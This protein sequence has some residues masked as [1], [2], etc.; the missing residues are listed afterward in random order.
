[1]ST[2]RRS[3]ITLHSIR[4]NQKLA[5][6]SRPIRESQL[7][8]ASLQLQINIRNKLLPSKRSTPFAAW[9]VPRES[10]KEYRLE[11]WAVEA[12]EASWDVRGVGGGYNRVGG[13]VIQGAGESKGS[14]KIDESVPGVTSVWNVCP[15]GRSP[16]L[17]WKATSGRR[18]SDA[19]YYLLPTT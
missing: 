14:G 10:V 3:H 12:D 17:N 19:R 9:I 1:M 6:R 16:R 15:C 2:Q 11:V 18:V 8:A 13:G 4:T 5:P 7:S